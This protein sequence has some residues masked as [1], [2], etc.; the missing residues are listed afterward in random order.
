MRY[1][2]LDQTEATKVLYLTPGRIDDFARSRLEHK[3]SQAWDAKVRE[4]INRYRDLA[5]FLNP[6]D[7]DASA[8]REVISWSGFPRRI[9]AWLSVLEDP[10]P[11][12]QARRM[13]RAHRSAE[14]L[15]RYTYIRLR[16]DGRF[17]RVP[18]DQA[19]GLLLYPEIN[20]SPSLE[21]AFSLTHRP[22]DE[23]LE[24]FVVRDPQTSRIA[25]IDFTVEPPEYWETLAET[26]G[27]LAQ[28]LYSDLL[29]MKVPRDDLFFRGD[30]LC[31]EY[32][33]SDGQ[34]QFVGFTR[35]FPEDGDFRAGQ[36]NR[37]NKWNTDFGIVHLT[38]PANTLFAEINLAALAT[39]RFAVR[40]DLGTSAD[41]FTL[42]ACGDYG[43]V[44]RNSDPTIGQAVNNLALSG[45]RVMVSDPI[46]L[47]VGEVDL[48]GFRDPK[49]NE[50]AR[51]EIL[52]VHRGKFKDDD[53][54]PRVLRFSIHVPNRADYGLESCTL[55]GHPLTT[56]G[57]IARATTVVIHGIAM[58][59]SDSGHPLAQCKAKPCAHATKQPDYYLLVEPPDAACPPN[60]DPRW[61][62]PP[63]AVA[64][65]GMRL[66]PV[67]T[68]PRNSS[69]RIA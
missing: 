52:T 64:P 17:Y 22:Q 21:H 6:L 37:L 38:Q 67:S 44:N 34:Y 49:G 15:E 25:R 23:Y 16:N 56:G 40:P 20:G 10:Q 14:I 29:R 45:F 30:I 54:L 42:T 26:D 24:W 63:V 33:E 53:G 8:V 43:E 2:R 55:N 11:R 36:Y 35:L 57:P 65:D 60:T 50:V 48:Q 32:V 19:S 47:Y 1:N 28:E 46:G 27:N 66:V 41:R 4:Q 68:T 59:G 61:D 13:D 9:D 3:L 58:N 62:K 7:A 18:A 31:R 69:K 39:Q 12:A 51:D 5:R